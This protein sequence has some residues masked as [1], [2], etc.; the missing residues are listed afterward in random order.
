MAIAIPFSS[1]NPEG[2]SLEVRYILGV[3]GGVPRQFAELWFT[4]D[5]ANEGES[6]REENSLLLRGKVL[7][8]GEGRGRGGLH[9]RGGRP[10]A[11][12]KEL[13]LS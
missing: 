12:Q 3:G 10:P 6:G 7:R 11:V 2:I 5:D 4:T 13:S 9:E 1:S 8:G